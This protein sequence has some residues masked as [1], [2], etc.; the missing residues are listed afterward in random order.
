VARL[1]AEE[2]GGEDKIILEGFSPYRRFGG[3]E[4]LK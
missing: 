1:I 4:A 2:T 3:G